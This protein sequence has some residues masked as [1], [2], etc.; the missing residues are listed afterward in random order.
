MKTKL[1]T[2]AVAASMAILSLTGCKKDAASPEKG[3]GTLKE[4]LV[5]SYKM[6]KLAIEQGGSSTD[7]LEQ[8]SSCD[9]DNIYVL[10]ADMTSQIIDAG[11]ECSPSS[12]DTGSW[13][14][15]DNN[16]IMMDDQSYHIDSMDGSTLKMS[17]PFEQDGVEATLRMTYVK[18]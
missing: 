5:G 1:F 9:R 18:Q 16:T 7:V 13:S 12:D 2:L 3:G 14:L 8:Y 10:K 6:T 17:V 11:E 4:K 15:P